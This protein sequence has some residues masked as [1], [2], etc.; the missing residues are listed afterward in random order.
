[1]IVITLAGE[2]S[3]FFSNGYSVV[4]YKLE[5]N[6][7]SII[8]NI[9]SYLPRDE[10]LLIIINKKFN[11][12]QYFT[13]LLKSMNFISFQIAEITKTRGQL[14]SVYLGLS[15][16][17]DFWNKKDYLTIYNG[18]T[19]RKSNV[20]KFKDCDGYI[21]VF[22]DKGDHWSFVD[23]L[24]D[25]KLVTEKNKISNF[26]SSGLYYFNNINLFIK[27]LEEYFNF[28]LNEFYIAPY[29]NILIKKNYKIKS[30]LNEIENFIFC[31]TPE[32]YKR[33]LIR[34]GRK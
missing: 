23:N 15:I 16:T 6:N 10:K 5:F 7:E 26:C 9:L 19:I 34:F 17:K 13:D 31:G 25:V 12:F 4:K 8:Y 11:D 27:Y 18:D 20:W 30:G 33:S 2:S 1:M 22:I 14:E 32:E 28:I 21:E 3:R 24:G 29:Y